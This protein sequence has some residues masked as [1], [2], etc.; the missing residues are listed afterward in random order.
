MIKKGGNSTNGRM[1]VLKKF[2]LEYVVKKIE[3]TYEAL[4]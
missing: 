2:G 1:F 4:L 3:D